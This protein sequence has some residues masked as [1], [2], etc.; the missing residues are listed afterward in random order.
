MAPH[1]RSDG[2]GR[3]V[4]HGMVSNRATRLFLDGTH[5]PDSSTVFDSHFLCGRKPRLIVYEASTQSFSS[6]LVSRKMAFWRSISFLSSV[7]SGM[8]VLYFAAKICSFPLSTL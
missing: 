7:S 1:W 5:S 8:Y 2:K 4:K 6:F 3:I